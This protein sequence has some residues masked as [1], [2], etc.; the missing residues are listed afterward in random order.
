[1]DDSQCQ[2]GQ[3]TTAEHGYEEILKMLLVHGV[4]GNYINRDDE[5]DDTAAFFIIRIP[6][7]EDT[8]KG[9]FIVSRT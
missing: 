9:I 1:M 7:L 5:P 2:M 3:D 8:H 6:R 4:G